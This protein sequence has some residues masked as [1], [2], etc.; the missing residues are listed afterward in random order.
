MLNGFVLDEKWVSLPEDDGDPKTEF[1]IR[2]IPAAKY[3]ELQGESYELAQLLGQELNGAVV[4]RNRAFVRE[5]VRWGVAG[6]RNG[7]GGLSECKTE[8]RIFGGQEFTVLADETL[9]VYE[10]TQVGSEPLIVDGKEIGRRPVYLIARLL[11]IVQ[12]AQTLSIDERRGLHGA[13]MAG[14]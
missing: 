1:L 8:K 9:A 4:A 11:E 13:G 3:D 10:R 14:T 12:K 5:Y 6:H 2:A 7:A